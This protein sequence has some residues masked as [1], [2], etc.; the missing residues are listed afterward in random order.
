MRAAA[1]GWRSLQTKSSDLMPAVLLQPSS[2]ILIAANLVPLIGVSVWGWDAFVLLML[3]WF[4]TAVIA[5][6]TVVRMATMSQADVEGLRFDASR[7]PTP[8]IMLAFVFMANAG[9]FMGIHFL[10]LWE[11]FSGGWADRIRGLGDFVG[12]MVIGTGLWVPLLVLFIARGLLMLFEIMKPALRRRFALAPPKDEPAK[13]DPAETILFGLYLR[14]LVLQVT[15]I[16]GA[17]IALLVGNAGALALLIL[18]KTIVDL[19]YDK[20]GDRFH[21]AW[22]KAKAEQAAKS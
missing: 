19:T 15:I 3:Y 5:F 6:W 10:F 14:I 11:L 17:S 4:E 8:P 18:V 13:L 1:V 20:L 9:G 12:Q 22:I 2:F 16:I 7:K 21:T